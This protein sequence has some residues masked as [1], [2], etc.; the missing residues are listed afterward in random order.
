MQSVFPAVYS[1]LCPNALAALI[2][3]EYNLAD[4]HCKL[5]VRGVGDSY[6][7]SSANQ[8][9]IIRVYRTTHR[10]LE[11][12]EEEVKLLLELQVA[13]VSVS[14]PIPDQQGQVIQKLPAAEGERYAVLFSY[15]YGQVV[16]T[17]NPFQL[18]ML[19]KE[20]ALFHNVTMGK[21]ADTVRWTFDLTYTLHRPLG[22]LNP[23]LEENSEGYAWLQSAVKQ[24]EKKLN[25]LE[26]SLF[27]SGF[28]HFDFLPKNFHFDV[29]KVTLFDFD[30]MGYGCLVN[31]I[32]SFWQ[33]LTLEVYTGRMQQAAADE[34]FDHFLN[35]YRQ[36]RF[37]SDQELAAI[38]YLSL[39]FWLFYMGFHTTHDQFYVFS[40]QSQVKLYLDLLKHIA[41]T[42]WN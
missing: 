19:G 9:Y 26:Y 7:V 23:V 13:G 28:C 39:G 38:P 36:H 30:F 18:Q 21:G 34:A 3:R 1:T 32:M 24:V 35:A 37:L 20:M 14:Y 8:R 17:M 25:D 42:Y 11:Q 40:N 29:D 10:K 12:I 15:A 22:L 33:H 6:L 27:P 5:L 4:V 31:D 41:K 16:R 2:E